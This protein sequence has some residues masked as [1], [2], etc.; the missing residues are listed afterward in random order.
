[1]HAKLVVYFNEVFVP[2][3]LKTKVCRETTKT[4]Y[5]RMKES[6][7]SE[8]SFDNNEY[9]QSYILHNLRPRTI[10]SAMF[11]KPC[12]ISQ[13]FII[14]Q[15]LTDHNRFIYDLYCTVVVG[16]TCTVTKYSCVFFWLY[17]QL[18]TVVIHSYENIQFQRKVWTVVIIKFEK[19][20]FFNRYIIIFY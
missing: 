10:L 15:Y 3:A 9:M 6:A 14:L 20:I 16:Q 11:I 7:T 17:L 8:W 13:E 1:M 4:V 2:S 5:K 19:N 18:E 12:C